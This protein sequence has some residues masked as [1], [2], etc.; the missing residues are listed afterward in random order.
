MAEMR[1]RKHRDEF[2]SICAHEE[3]WRKMHEFSVFYF[4]TLLC[5]D[6]ENLK[7]CPE[8]K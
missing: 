3:R 5:F 1:V 2:V 7:K 6:F 8:F 4:F